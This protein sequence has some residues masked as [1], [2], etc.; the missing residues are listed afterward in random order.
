[1]I[2]GWFALRQMGTL[3]DPGAVASR[4]VVASGFVLTWLLGFSPVPA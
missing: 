4:S 2:A 1:V 3:N